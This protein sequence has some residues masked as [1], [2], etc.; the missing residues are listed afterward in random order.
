VIVNSNDNDF[1]DC[2]DHLKKHLDNNLKR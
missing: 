2:L 1:P